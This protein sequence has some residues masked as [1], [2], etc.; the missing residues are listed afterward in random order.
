MYYVGANL[1]GGWLNVS[2]NV[3]QPLSPVKKPVANGG[4][5]QGLTQGGK[6]NYNYEHIIHLLL[7]KYGWTLQEIGAWSWEK[8]DGR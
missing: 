2:F 1:Y 4:Q 3:K 8:P 7:N 5:Q 6:M